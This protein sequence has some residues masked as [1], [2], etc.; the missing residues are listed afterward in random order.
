MC[1]DDGSAQ[2][3]L[4]PR[5]TD[6]MMRCPVPGIGLIESSSSSSPTD[7]NVPAPTKHPMDAGLLLIGGVCGIPGAGGNMQI[8][9]VESLKRTFSHKR[10]K[11][12]TNS[13]TEEEETEERDCGCP[14]YSISALQK[15]DERTRSL[16]LRDHA[17]IRKK[18][19]RD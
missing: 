10:A 2:I 6:A 18:D 1:V 12:T 8:M 9:F 7:N 17:S 13:P 3:E 5:P 14:Q 15:R 11:Q 19:N 4:P 16:R